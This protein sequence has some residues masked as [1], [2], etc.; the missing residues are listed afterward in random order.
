MTKRGESGDRV[1]RYV[2]VGQK[3]LP[4]RRFKAQSV[5]YYALMPIDQYIYSHELGDNDEWRF[6]S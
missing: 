2:V 5:I 3:C 6:G 1:P 4:S